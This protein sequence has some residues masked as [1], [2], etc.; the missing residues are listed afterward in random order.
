MATNSKTK[1]QALLGEH[2]FALPSDDIDQVKTAR[3]H[4]HHD[5]TKAHGDFIADHLCGS[6]Q[7]AQKAYL[8][9]EDQPAMMMPYTSKD[10]M[11]IKNNKP[12]FTF[13]STTSGPKG[14]TAH[15][16]MTGMMVITGP[17]KTSLNW[18]WSA[19]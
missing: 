18:P 11:A 15:A 9:F 14:I 13:A 16:A 4:Q 19:R 2:A 5:Q 7:R 17:K 12:A 6:T 8:E 10:V 3:N 1:A